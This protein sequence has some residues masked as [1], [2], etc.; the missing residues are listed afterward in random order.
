MGGLSR[1]GKRAPKAFP[2]GKGG[3]A[4]RRSDEEAH[5]SAAQN[6]PAYTNARAGLYPAG[7]NAAPARNSLTDEAERHIA[8]SARNSA[9]AAISFAAREQRIVPANAH[10]GLDSGENLRYNTDDI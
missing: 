3:R 4:D 6:S 10:K 2:S 9:M 5:F 7:T 8:A 1:F